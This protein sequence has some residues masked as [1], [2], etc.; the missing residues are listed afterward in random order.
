MAVADQ[1]GQEPQVD[2]FRQVR[3][4]M[5]LRWTAAVV[6][7]LFVGGAIG[8]A[9]GQPDDAPGSDS[10]DVGFLYDMTEHHDQALHM[11]NLLLMNGE[12]PHVAVFA[13]EILRSQS[14]EIGA[15]RRQLESWGYSP[16]AERPAMGWMGHETAV[17]EMQGMATSAEIDALLAARGRDADALFIAL[18]KDH[19]RGGIEMA[20]AAAERAADP[21]VQELA[22]LMARN[23]RFEISEL[24]QARVRVGLAVAPTGYT[25]DESEDHR[26]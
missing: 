2:I 17:D 12:S 9:V 4:E 6:A 7:L 22:T 16:E 1:G 18:M 14:L 8:F 26:R 19:H 15:M 20:T 11:S 10:A 21:F 24:E 13:R 3:F 5:Y 23:Q 25:P